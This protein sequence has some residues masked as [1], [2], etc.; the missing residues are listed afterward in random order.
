MS[1][2]FRLVKIPFE[3]TG[4]NLGG[5]PILQIVLKDYTRDDSGVPAITPHCYCEVELMGEI[6]RLKQEL[7]QI[8]RVGKRHYR[9][10][11]RTNL[12]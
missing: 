10:A 12:S 3:P 11:E 6:K 7:D 4:K 8:E 2:S 1:Y 5:P 9:R